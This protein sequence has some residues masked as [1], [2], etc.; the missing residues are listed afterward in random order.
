[1]KDGKVFAIREYMDSLYVSRLFEQ[2]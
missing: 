1:M 2:A